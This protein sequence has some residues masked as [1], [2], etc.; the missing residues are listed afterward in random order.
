M[1]PFVPVSLT[2]SL[3]D[4]KF[5]IVCDS[6]FTTHR[7]D[8]PDSDSAH[9]D[10]DLLSRYATAVSTPATTRS[11]RGHGVRSAR[12][13][14]WSRAL[15]V[16]RWNSRLLALILS[17]CAFV[18]FLNVEPHHSSTSRAMSVVKHMR[19]RQCRLL[20][21]FSRCADPFAN[22][23]FRD[24]TGL[25]VYPA[26]S[27]QASPT[28]P[29]LVPPQPHPIH[30]LIREAEA[31]WNDKV[32][33]QSRTLAEAVAEYRR[34]YGIAP[35]RGF[36]R[37]Y[38][39]ATAHNVSLIDEYDS[40]QS[41]VLPF[42]ALSPETLQK[43]SAML[44]N[45][46]GE[47]EWWLHQHT[48]TV[49]IRDKGTEV[50]ADGPMRK[51]NYRADQLIE[52]L[53]GISQ[54]LPDLN[55]T[56]TGHDVPWVTMSGEARQQHIAA[57]KR[58]EWID[59]V[60][61]YH[62][63]WSLEGFQTLCPPGSPIRDLGSVYNRLEPTPP[64]EV[65][66]IGL[67]HRKAMDIC[68]FPENQ[69]QHGYT[70]W[71]G[72]RPGILFPL[73]SWTSSLLNSDF[74]LPALEQYE[75]PVGPDPAWRDKSL[76]KAVWRGST[77]G[78]D[79]TIPHARKHSQRVRLARLPMT[80]G[81]IV[82]PIAP[83]DAP[84]FPGPVEELSGSA[85]D[86]A[87]EFLDIKFQGRAQQCGTPEM[88]QKFEQEFEWDGYMSEAQQN[89]YKYVIDVD[90]NGWSGRFHRLM[91]SNSLVLKSTIFPE[92]YADRVQPWVHYVPLKVDYSDLFS[93]MTFFRGSPYDGSGSH[94]D[95][96]EKIA[97]AGA[98]WAKSMWR[99]QDMQAYLLR[100]VLEYARIMN[101]D[102]PG[103]TNWDY[104][105]SASTQA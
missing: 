91:S 33:R 51:T 71:N 17:T 79:L 72:P 66:F 55:L 14:Y 41:Q 54:Y 5:A 50:S 57:A 92:W 62:D 43:R 96:A 13:R 95:L 58:G 76:N 69:P 15:S 11:P 90:G 40:I 60:A 48:V 16:K 38:A 26:I 105:E 31:A 80:T 86:F 45:T 104:D 30:Y 52:L 102:S 28:S 42:A 82:V 20:P 88:C 77:T 10:D 74:L 46:T 94:D 59:D 7:P 8:S 99:W 73:F 6:G 36:D 19:Q 93:I 4:E 70:A 34:R 61:G 24:E 67:D 98:E 100:L 18:A 64:E 85:H 35:P 53:K 68:Y 27:A 49:K 22:L 32:S 12:A 83:N 103:G 47:P 2:P 63:D 29:T 97:T 3:V 44:Q 75:R 56:I 81:H 1:S 39:F 23:K 21:K 25:L 84:G 87:D 9:S 37:W 78:S 101:R 89:E 65:S